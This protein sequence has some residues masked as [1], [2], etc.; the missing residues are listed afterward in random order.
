MTPDLLTPE[1][2][3]ER[4]G[5]LT[6][7]A[8]ADALPGWRLHPE[9]LA[10]AADLV[11]AVVRENYPSLAVPFHARWRHFPPGQWEA[12]R[13]TL[14]PDERPL[15]AFDLAITSVLLDAGAGMGWRWRD[16]SGAVFSKSEGLAVASLAMFARGDFGAPGRADGAV[17]ATITAE[18]LAAGFQVTPENPLVG[19]EGRAALLRRLGKAL[20]R[21]GALF[22]ILAAQA[23]AGTLPARNILI[24]VLRHL[25]PIWP[26]RIERDGVNLGD[27]WRHPSIPDDGLIPF[28]KLSQWLSYSLV[29][30]LQG[31]GIA[32]TGLDALTG[33]PEYRNGGLFFDTGVIALRDPLDADRDHAADAPLIIGWR[34]LTVSLLDRIAPLVRARLGVT[35]DTFPLACVLEGGTWAAGRRL[36]IAARPDGGPPLRVIS[37][38]TVF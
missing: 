6:A 12:L 22:G 13:D 30:P 35:A 31:A 16:A 11:T 27:C 38:G 10:N 21:P 26:G 19:L 25:G 28:H 20:P 29:E 24:A 1:A 36:A 33:L 8:E 7:L 17:L 32:V 14:P 4:A 18:Q 5:I 23:Q 34:A 15:A 37:D 9:R 2:V 3:R